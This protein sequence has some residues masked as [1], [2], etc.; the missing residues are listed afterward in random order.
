MQDHADRFL[1]PRVGFFHRHGEAGEFVVAVAFADAEIQPSARQQI[2]RRRLLGQQHGVVPGQHDHRGAEPQ[3]A[4]AGAEP[5]EQVERG[6]DLAE[7]GE[8]VL[9]DEGAVEAERL[10]FDVVFDEVAE[11]FGA[12]ELAAAAARRRA[13]EQT[14]PH[15]VALLSPL[16]A[17]G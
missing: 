11:A 12:V 4:G 13:A 14:E 7:A 1:E 9:D 5:G 16:C 3:R 6:G 10:G 8:V 17:G 15:A 2:Q